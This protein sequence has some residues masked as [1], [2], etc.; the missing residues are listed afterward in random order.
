MKLTIDDQRDMTRLRRRVAIETR[1]AKFLWRSVMVVWLLQAILTYT[2]G[3]YWPPARLYNDIFFIVLCLMLAM[4]IPLCYLSV[5]GSV[6]K[7][8]ASG[9]AE[10]L[11]LLSAR[12][13]ATRGRYTRDKELYRNLVRILRE[14]EESR[15]NLSRVQ[16]L[17]LCRW[18]Y[19]CP[20]DAG[21][22]WNEIISVLS[23][24]GSRDAI[25]RM[26]LHLPYSIIYKRCG[27][28]R[29]I[30]VKGAIRAILERGRDNNK[31]VP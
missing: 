4:M 9:T 10:D 18:L 11:W 31:P 19:A 26:R 7:L 25:L 24:H 15:S 3:S 30:A 21:D 16:T 12:C 17:A 23:K 1:L 6:A 20:G 14:G 5:S 8:A 13:L 2:E 27:K 28:E 22:F 29:R